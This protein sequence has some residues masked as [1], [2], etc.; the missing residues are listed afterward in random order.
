MKDENTDDIEIE[1]GSLIGLELT[2][3]DI[4]V[5]HQLPKG[6]YSAAVREGCKTT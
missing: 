5:S 1:V 4:S 6:S 2:R 3:N